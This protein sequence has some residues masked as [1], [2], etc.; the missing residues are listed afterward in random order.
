[1]ENDDIVL[2]EWTANKNAECNKQLQ[3]QSDYFDTTE[4]TAK[5]NNSVSNSNSDIINDQLK[6][7]LCNNLHNS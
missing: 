5:D 7:N 2:K 4:K 1:M 6:N 3:S